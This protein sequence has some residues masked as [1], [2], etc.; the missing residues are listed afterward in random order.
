[1]YEVIQDG[2]H[3]VMIRGD[4][5]DEVHVVAVFHFLEELQRRF[6]N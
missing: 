4:S 2:Q 3:F 6:K 1:M 5:D